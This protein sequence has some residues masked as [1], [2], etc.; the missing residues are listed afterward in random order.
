MLLT[1]VQ[2]KDL[3]LWQYCKMRKPGL[4]HWTIIS[5]YN[6][7]HKHSKHLFQICFNKRA[8]ILK[9]L[10]ILKRPSQWPRGRRPVLQSTE[11]WIGGFESHSVR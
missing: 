9:L 1:P 10:R 6:P 8:A 7:D 2:D 11:Y 3:R 4:Q 5:Y